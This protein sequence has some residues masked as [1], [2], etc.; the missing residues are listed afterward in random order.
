MPLEMISKNFGVGVAIR[1]EQVPNRRT[2][3]RVH[4]DR[5]ESAMQHLPTGL[6]KSFAGRY[7]RPTL[8]I[9]SLEL[10]NVADIRRFRQLADV[11]A[12]VISG[13]IS[14]VVTARDFDHAA[15]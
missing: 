9:Y 10:D 4:E 6:G 13:F 15:E 5:A 2:K 1:F 14:I 12:H 8:E 7:I 11:C 3:F